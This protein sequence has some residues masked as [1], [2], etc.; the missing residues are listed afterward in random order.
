MIVDFMG[1]PLLW[2]HDGRLPTDRPDRP[3]VRLAHEARGAR[4]AFAHRRGLATVATAE[5]VSLETPTGPAT[6]AGVRISDDS[7]GFL[8]VWA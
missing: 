4:L 3:V 5:M 8:V 2:A 6:A 7:V 1:R